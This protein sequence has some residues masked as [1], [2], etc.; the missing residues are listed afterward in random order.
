MISEIAYEIVSVLADKLTFIDK[1]CG[2]V[3]PIKKSVAGVEKTI[4]M[5]VNTKSNCNVSD[6][7]D[8]VPDS[9]K[10]SICYIEKLG[11]PE[12]EPRASIFIANCNLRVVLWY[13]LNLINEGKYLDEDIIAHNI[14][15]NM[16]KTIPDNDL[17]TA[18][19]VLIT[20]LGTSGGAKL[21]SGY[22]YNEVKN[23]FVTFPY[24]AVSVDINVQYVINKCAETLIPSPICS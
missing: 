17:I 2:V 16:P 24:G 9:S 4:P 6:Y 23:Q 18:K 3:V 13:N 20:I 5:Y 11:E 12:F 1:W 10:K 22:T 15:T 7:M 21:F 8:L 19:R 14:I